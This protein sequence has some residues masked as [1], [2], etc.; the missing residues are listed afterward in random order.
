MTVFVSQLGATAQKTVNAP[1]SKNLSAFIRAIYDRRA[2]AFRLPWNR[3]QQEE[4]HDKETKGF[5]TDRAAD[6]RC[7]HRHSGGHR[8][9]EPAHR[10]AAVEA[11]ADDGRYP[12]HRHGVGSTRH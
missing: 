5:H 7:D 2:V 3:L 9:S 6:R 8:H 4:L 1:S 11:E 12:F 10:N